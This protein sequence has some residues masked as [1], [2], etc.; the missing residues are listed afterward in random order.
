[1][2]SRSETR[3]WR[4]FR[5]HKPYPVT[6]TLLIICIQLHFGLATCSKEIC[7]NQV[8]SISSGRS[9]HWLT[10]CNPLYACL[11][12]AR[13]GCYLDYFVRFHS[14]DADHSSERGSKKETNPCAVAHRGVPAFLRTDDH[15]DR[16]TR[17]GHSIAAQSHQDP[18]ERQCRTVEHE[19]KGHRRSANGP[20]ERSG[21]R[22]SSLSSD[23]VQPDS[24]DPGSLNRG[25]AAAPCPRPY[26]QDR[27]A[28]APASS[29]TRCGFDRSTSCFANDLVPR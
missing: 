13:P 17:F 20:D 9:C 25:G 21:P 16:R 26:R 23:S 18:D 5:A 15:V 14:G 29:R 1:M 24:V 28:P 8:D 2:P 3:V 19:G 11:C 10:S 22:A 4:S 27:E 12:E 7:L 6:V